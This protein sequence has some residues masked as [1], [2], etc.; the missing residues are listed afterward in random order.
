M[1][2]KL[3]IIS[4]FVVLMVLLLETS[5]K[6]SP[7]DEPYSQV[8]GKYEWTYTAYKE[9]ALSSYKYK[10]PNEQLNAEIEFL[11]HRKI[12][13]YINGDQIASGTYNVVDES[14]TSNGF[15]MDIKIKI[16]EGSLEIDNEVSV[17][18]H[19]SDSLSFSE[20]PYGSYENIDANNRTNH[21]VRE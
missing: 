8:L 21:F 1:I 17:S 11:K 3:K 6:K 4:P 2:R 9:T 16:K 14:E 5:C 15:S 12:Q 7:L 19:S 20:F 13:F 10:Y 18:L